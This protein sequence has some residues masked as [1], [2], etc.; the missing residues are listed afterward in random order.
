MASDCG[1]LTKRVGYSGQ[2]WNTTG[3]YITLNVVCVYKLTSTSTYINGI[4]IDVTVFASSSAYDDDKESSM[5]TG[6]TK[7]VSIDWDFAIYIVV[8]PTSSSNAIDI[9]YKAVRTVKKILSTFEKNSECR[10]SYW[11]YPWQHLLF[12]YNYRWNNRYSCILLCQESSN[13]FK[14]SSRNKNGAATAVQISPQHQMITD[15]AP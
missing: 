6:G 4:K 15:L 3:S 9:D 8:H 11:D 13:G 7:T 14:K 10:S 1:T 5:S 2:T 12:H